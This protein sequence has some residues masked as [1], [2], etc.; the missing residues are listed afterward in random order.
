MEGPFPAF[1]MRPPHLAAERHNPPM[2]NIASL[3]RAEI[4]R[5]ARKE[6]RNELQALKK[7][8]S[9]H[10][11]EIAALKRRTQALEQEVKRLCRSKPSP[12]PQPQAAP[13]SGPLRFSPTR[14]QAQR[15]R[16]GLSARQFGQLVGAS[17]QS[18]YKWEAGARPGPDLLAAIAVLRKLSKREVAARLAE[19]E[20]G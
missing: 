16:L 17:D 1:L 14:L 6:V 11:A 10:R 5:V 12:T 7:A 9:A 19:L 4:S 2:T 15:K 3:L 8:A 18:V 13:P 20:A